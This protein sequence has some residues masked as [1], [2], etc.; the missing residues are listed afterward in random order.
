MANEDSTA[1]SN[2]IRGLESMVSAGISCVDYV[3]GDARIV[4][5]A[6]VHWSSAVQT[7]VNAGLVYFDFLTAYAHETAIDVVM[8]VCSPAVT[9]GILIRTHVPAGGTLPTLTSVFPG[10]NWCERETTE[11]FGVTFNGHPD[12]RNLLLPN[13]FEGHPLL[14]SYALTP[15]VSQTWPGDVE[16]ADPNARP[17]ARR[18]SLPPGVLAEWSIDDDETQGAP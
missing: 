5:V 7:A 18:K 6:D 10:A 9:D 17:R 14:K 15:R 13:D 12:P 2:A 11:M 3:G 1:V 16:P 8:H 4:D